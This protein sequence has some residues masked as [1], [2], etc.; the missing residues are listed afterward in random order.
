MNATDPDPSVPVMP[1]PASSGA[2]SE[3]RPVAEAS[4]VRPATFIV[5]RSSTHQRLR[6]L[7]PLAGRRMP[8]TEELV[9]PRR[10]C[11]SHVARVT[12]AAAQ[13][14]KRGQAGAQKRQTGGFGKVGQAFR[15]RCNLQA[16]HF[17]EAGLAIMAKAM[18]FFHCLARKLRHSSRPIGLEDNARCV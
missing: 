13:H 10:N 4:C 16:T 14:T 11:A 18:K 17:E 2:E 5:S 3:T 8:T 1:A 9:Q 6:F 15:A 7:T 12:L